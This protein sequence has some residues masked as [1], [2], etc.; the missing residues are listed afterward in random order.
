MML[1]FTGCSLI[2]Q[3][4]NLLETQPET[5]KPKTDELRPPKNGVMTVAVY[6]F[7]D[8]TGQRRYSERV[9]S[10]SSAV[11][12]G[13]DS[14]LIQALQ[15]VGRGQWFR[16]VERGGIENLL[17]ERQIIR[18]MRELYEGPTA[19]QMSPLL[20]AG[21][22]I[23]GGIIGY[24]TN[25]VTGGAGARAFGIGGSTEYRTDL[26]T[27]TL[28]TVSVTTGEVLITVTTTKRIHSYVDKMG[29]LKF[30]SGGTVSWEGEVGSSTNDSVN[31]AIQLAIQSSVREMVE[32]G[33]RRGLWEYQPQ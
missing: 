15:S 2:D 23:D 22:I 30:V 17:R 6:R 25:I 7:N 8:Q 1:G 18:Q 3:T 24:D 26:V 29:V 28:R 14:Y 13:A 21:L 32:E 20:F 4:T 10:L 11:T 19:R 33:V 16:V 5:V 27:V 12:Q 9:A 31:L